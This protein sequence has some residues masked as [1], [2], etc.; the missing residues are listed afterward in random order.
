MAVQ[1]NTCAQCKTCKSI[2]EIRASS[3][4]AYREQ[5]TMEELVKFTPGKDG[6]PGYFMSALPI[7]PFNHKSV[8]GNR[9][10]ANIQNRNM[11]IKL[12]KDPEALE[13][14][15]QE[16]K[17]LM[18]LGFIKKL[19]D[20]PKNIQ[21]EINSDFKHFIPTTVAFKE[22]SA[23]TKVRICWDSSHQSPY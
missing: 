1:C 11:V 21:D 14:V 5:V 22:T 23:S 9:M 13:G 4:N 16:M 3:Y 15:R 10:T 17:K 19:K 20:L 18:A 8:K 7:K 12:N 6:E 2:S